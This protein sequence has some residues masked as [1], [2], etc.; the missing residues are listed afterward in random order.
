M[1]SP[2]THRRPARP[3]V[4]PLIVR[5]PP[6][7][8]PGS[9]GLD[10]WSTSGRPSP[11]HSLNLA[12]QS[13][14]NHSHRSC[15]PSRKACAHTNGRAVDDTKRSLKLKESPTDRGPNNLNLVGWY[16]SAAGQTGLNS[17]SDRGSHHGLP[18]RRGPA[19]KLE[20]VR[21]SVLS[22]LKYGIGGPSDAPVRRLM[23]NR[24]P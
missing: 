12:H 15:A 9:L 19:A 18:D 11:I 2:S 10:S 5:V 3:R 22:T 20:P 7:K 17:L 24:A 14:S 1:A 21:Q 13:Q 16:P 23:P 6:Q 4:D 8:A